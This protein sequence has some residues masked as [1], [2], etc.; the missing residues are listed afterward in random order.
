MK[1]ESPPARPPRRQPR[2]PPF[3]PVPIRTR[4]DGWTAL[5]Q[6]NFLG[7]LA[8]TGSVL[9]ACEA[10]GM[11]RKSAYQLRARRGAES[12]AAAWDVALGAPWRK[13]TVGDLEFLAHHGLIRLKFFRGRY[14][15][16]WRK[17]DVSAHFRWLAQLDR[18]TAG[19]G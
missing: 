7:M 15:G 1:P 5:R 18:R 4:S 6:A 10:V 3:Y 9:G 16:P 19:H 2:V 11:S 12:F 14:R 13:V 8:E 17:P